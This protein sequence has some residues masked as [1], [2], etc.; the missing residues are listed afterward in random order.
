MTPF[1]FSFFFF[2]CQHKFFCFLL[3]DSILSENQKIQPAI[4]GLLTN[5]KEIK[6]TDGHDKARHFF[7]LILFFYKPVLL[8]FL[9]LPWEKLLAL[10]TAYTILGHLHLHHLQHRQHWVTNSS[11]LIRIAFLLIEYL[12]N[13]IVVT[14]GHPYLM[15]F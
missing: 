3:N 7:Y 12:G 5:K 10:F 8:Y 4:F 11:H 1:F 13:I 15:M 14:A 2:K 6:L 9:P